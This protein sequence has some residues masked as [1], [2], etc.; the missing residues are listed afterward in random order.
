M[1]LGDAALFLNLLSITAFCVL[2]MIAIVSS[3]IKLKSLL[4]LDFGNLSAYSAFSR[5]RILWL[6]TLSPWLVGF[7]AAALVLLTGSSYLPVSDL[8]DLL[9]WHHPQEFVFLSWHGLSTLLAISYVGFVFIQNVI[10]L[11]QNSRQIKLLHSLAE[12]DYDGFYQLDADAPTAFTA[13]YT[14]PQCYITSALRSRLNLEE[15]TIVQLHEQAH[16]RQFDP[17]KKWFYQ[18]LTAFFPLSVSR[19]LEQSMVLAMEQCADSAVTRVI[20]DKSKIAMTLI[21]V[22]RLAVNPFANLD[23]RSLCHY[24][25]DNIP[26]RIDYLLSSKNKKSFP[27]LQIILIASSMSIICAL[28]ADIFHHAIEYTLS[29]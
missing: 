5:R 19:Q 14:R 9:H 7:I 29:H 27:T 6:V 24:G 8:F 17:L 25:I 16:A 20:T 28:S 22:R 21:K 1:L 2:L 26:Q 11:V 12:K 10:R 3:L 15:Y 18:L 13:G 4:K 23:N